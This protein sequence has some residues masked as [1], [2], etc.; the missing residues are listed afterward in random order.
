MFDPNQVKQDF[1]ILSRL[2]PETQ[3]PLVYL[4]SAATSQKP[5]QVIEAISH[6]YEH[7]NANVHRGIHLLS[8]ES[9]VEFE[10]SRMTIAGFF[11]A[12]ADELIL[13]RNTTE[14]ING[15]AGGWGVDNIQA[16]D[17]VLVSLLEHHSNFVPWQQ[18]CIK[19]GAQFE[20][21]PVTTEGI[22][23]REWFT[24]HLDSQVKL[25]CLSQVSNVLG[26]KTDVAWFAQQAHR[27][28]A[29]V[30][31]D[32]AQ[33]AP[34]ISINFHDLDVDFLAFS[35]HKMLGPMGVGGLLV[36]H[37]LL[38]AE[39]MKPWLWGGGMIGEVTTE[40]TTMNSELGER[41]VAGTPDVASAVGLAAAC[42]YL[43]KLGLKEVEQHN[44]LLVAFALEKLSQIPEI[45]VIGPVQDGGRN[46]VGSVAFMYRG[47]HAHDVA[48]ILESEGVAVRSGHHCAMPL[49]THF[50]WPATVRASFQVYTT[51]DDILALVA[52]LQKVKKVFG[53]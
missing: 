33:S 7:S 36:K 48:Q 13:T 8:E 23:D 25:V 12:Q 39:E 28:G 24:E 50:G 49:H 10:Q 17:R 38:Q 46:R 53:K 20:V 14:A 26:T 9:T 45:Q 31:V 21:I 37:E 35:G 22:I 44:Q 47:V 3:Q 30:L 29:K 6:F 11:G 2:H 32:A 18:L 52:A 5:R 34:H 43:T 15:V 1:P 16:G 41:F 27:V 19:V 42:E 4:D 51:E 40:E